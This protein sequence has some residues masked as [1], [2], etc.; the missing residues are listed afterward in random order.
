M[1]Y[2]YPGDD[3][4]LTINLLSL[5][6]GVRFILLLLGARMSGFAAFMYQ[7]TEPLVSPFRGV[8]PS[9]QVGAASLETAS[10][11]AIFVLHL[12]GFI[13]AQI[14]GLFSRDRVVDETDLRNV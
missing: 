5:D 1:T 12:I 8:F 3:V 13:V 9:M 10:L 6:V 2:R 7:L 4:M 14:L 11:L